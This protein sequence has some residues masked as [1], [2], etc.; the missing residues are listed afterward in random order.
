MAVTALI[1]PEMKCT[2]FSSY[3]FKLILAVLLAMNCACLFA[4]TKG[5][6]N[7]IYSGVPW[8]DERGKP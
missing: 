2:C 5:K 3:A 7:A 6:Y 1:I 4:Q 8:F